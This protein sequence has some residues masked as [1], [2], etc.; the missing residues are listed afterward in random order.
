MIAGSQAS[1]DDERQLTTDG[2]SERG[3]QM[4]QWSSNSKSF[5][6][7]RVTDGERKEVYRIESSPRDGGRAVLHTSVYPLPGDRFTSYELNVFILKETDDEGERW[8]SVRPDVEPIDFGRPRLRWEPDGGKFTYTKVDR[9]HQRYRV[10]EVDATTGDARAL[11]DEQSDTFV[12]TMH[13]ENVNVDH[14]TWLDSS[15]ELIY[16]SEV[17]GW[18]HLYLIDPSK[19]NDDPDHGS[20]QLVNGEKRLFAPGLQQQ[21]TKGEFVVRGVDLVDEHGRQIWFNASGYNADQDPYFRHYYRVNLDGTGLVALTEGNGNH[22]IE[23]SPDRRFLID[24]Y[25]RVDMPPVHE[26]RRTDDGSLVC[27]LEAADISGLEQSGWRAPEVFVAKARDGETDIWGIISWPTDY[28]PSKK[29]PVL[30]DLYAG[31]HSAYVPKNFSGRNRYAALNEMGFIVVK[32]D[33]MGTAHRSKAFHD[34]CWK[35]LKDAGFEDRILWM[36]AAAEKYEAFDLDRVGV[37]GVSAGGQNAAAAVLFHG[38][39]YKAAVAGC[40]CHDNRMD[41]YSWNEQWMGYPVGPQYSASSN[42]DNAHRLNGKLFLIVGEM[43]TNVPP[44]STLRFVDALIKADKDFDML[45]VPGAGHGIGGNY[46]RRRMHD[47]FVRH[48]MNN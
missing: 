28:D 17:D 5:V 46:G 41:K 38:D 10:I 13:A 18:R 12:W 7:F 23:Y 8:Q 15:G 16:A 47:F 34:V 22:S 11:L 29:Y 43:D 45:L 9:G 37:Y 31:P 20:A 1:D 3:Y 6:A 19:G 26:L 27:Q 2:T 36:K 21:I 33:G 35:N 44:E 48:L 30:E 39:F 14:V 4:I 32:M 25:S 24:T 40:G 42:I